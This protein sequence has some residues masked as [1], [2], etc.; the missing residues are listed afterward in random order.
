MSWFK[1]AGNFVRRPTT[2]GAVAPSSRHLGERVV[3]GLD[4]AAAST[5]VELGP[6]TGPISE[7]VL[8]RIGPDTKF[9]ALELNPTFAKILRER[10]PTLQ[11]YN[12]SAETLPQRLSEHGAPHAD[13]ILCGLPWASL[14]EEVQDRVFQAILDGLAPGGTFRS[15]GYVHCRRFPKAV[16]FRQRLDDH[17]SKVE[18]SRTVFRNL[19]PAFVYRCVR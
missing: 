9:F 19:P 10:F 15:F 6:G 11:V 14:P 4:L 1:F 3:E 7:V 2:V 16:R 5:V 13:H 18:V 17:F 12:E 8:E